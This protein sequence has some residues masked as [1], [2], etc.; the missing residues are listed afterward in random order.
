MQR[1]RLT[2]KNNDYLQKNYIFITL[3][4]LFI[5]G[6]VYGALIIKTQSAQLYEQLSVL[7]GSYNYKENQ[8]IHTLFSSFFSNTIFLLVPYFAGYGAIFQLV[9]AFVPLFKGLGLGLSMGYIYQTE[10]LGGIGYCALIII[11]HTAVALIA[12]IIGCRESIKMSNLFFKSIKQ[13]ECLNLETIK[14]YNVKFIVLTAI[15]FIAALINALSVM[16]F[17]GIFK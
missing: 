11:P 1:T 8:F 6:M 3:I 12:I 14:L 15:S 4:L 7:T 16:L 5:I 2:L 17:F 9:P 13:S 10:G